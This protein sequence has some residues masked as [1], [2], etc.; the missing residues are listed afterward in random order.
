MQ[1]IP[2]P[3]NIGRIYSE[4]GKCLLPMT[5]LAGGYSFTGNL[6]DAISKLYQLMWM[7]TM[8]RREM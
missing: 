5:V 1:K 2:T 7:A 8:I 4:T 3:S 6:V